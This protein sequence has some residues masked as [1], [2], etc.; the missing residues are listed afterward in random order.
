MK[1][2]GYILSVI[3]IAAISAVYG[4]Y[5]LTVAWSW[6]VAPTF[7]LSELSIPVA[8]GIALIVNFM[9]NEHDIKPSDEPFT[10]VMLRGFVRAIIRPTVLIGIGWTVTLFM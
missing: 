1:A 6:F 2:L 10:D 4:G 8:Y 9:G 5:A 3:I 7:G